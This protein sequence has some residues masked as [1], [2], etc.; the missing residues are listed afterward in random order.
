[1]DLH[2]G[3]ENAMMLYWG[4][5]TSPEISARVQAAAAAIESILGEDL[6]DL[7]PS[8][9][10]LLIVYDAMRTD[11]LSVAHRVKNALQ[12]LSDSSAQ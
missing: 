5:G 3:G 4:D 7:V 12:Q 9:A 2:S 10:S 6:T 8:Y 11:H 1:M